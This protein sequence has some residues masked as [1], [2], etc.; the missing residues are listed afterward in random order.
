MASDVDIIIDPIL[1]AK[2]VNKVEK[3]LVKAGEDAGEKS[4][5]KA[6]KEFSSNLSLIHI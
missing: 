1:G 3:D 2:A 6:G 4:G 5:K